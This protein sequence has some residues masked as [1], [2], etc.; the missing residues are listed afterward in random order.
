MNDTNPLAHL[1]HIAA[2][3]LTS[4]ALK[5]FGSALMASGPAS[6][7]DEFD[8]K[9]E[10]RRTEARANQSFTHVVPRSLLIS[11]VERHAYSSQT[12]VPMNGARY[13]VGVCPA[14]ADGGP[15]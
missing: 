13:L 12:F 2:M 3:P 14:T 10:N 4:D 1:G 6:H 8:G 9:I 5:G 7:R 15:V 11:A